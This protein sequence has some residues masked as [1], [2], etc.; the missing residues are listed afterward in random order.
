M[1][2]GKGPKAKRKLPLGLG[3]EPQTLPTAAKATGER[4]RNTV[5]GGWLGGKPPKPNKK[6]R[7]RAK[8]G[9]KKTGKRIKNEGIANEKSR[10]NDNV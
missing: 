4:K 5:S 6:R 2:T 3:A 7:K 9:R 8:N 1:K 10:C